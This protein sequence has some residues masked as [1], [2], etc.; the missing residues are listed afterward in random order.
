MPVSL[1]VELPMKMML[2]LDPKFFSTITGGQC[3]MRDIK[4]TL[5][6]DQEHCDFS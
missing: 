6:F 3:P 5:L 4:K 2:D 1:F